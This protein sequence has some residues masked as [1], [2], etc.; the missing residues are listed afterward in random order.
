[1]NGTI[2][3]LFPRQDDLAE[4]TTAP[5][6]PVMPHIVDIVVQLERIRETTQNALSVIRACPT[7]TN[8]MAE[9]LNE[10]CDGWI[11]AEAANAALASVLECKGQA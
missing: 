7:M 9:L 3:E 11:K 4:R 5:L 1:M 8:A 6:L 2:H 10:I